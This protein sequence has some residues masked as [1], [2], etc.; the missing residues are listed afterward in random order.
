[1]NLSVLSNISDFILCFYYAACPCGRCVGEVA[2]YYGEGR[3]ASFHFSLM[4]GSNLRIPSYQTAA[5]QSAF[6][7]IERYA[8]GRLGKQLN[9]KK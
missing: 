7:G 2:G 1:M 5:I 6:T 4:S 9:S 3:A 8:H